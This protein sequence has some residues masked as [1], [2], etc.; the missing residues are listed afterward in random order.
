MTTVPTV[1]LPPDSHI[2][3][4]AV[5]AKALR[6]NMVNLDKY[7]LAQVKIDE[8]IPTSQDI[9]VRRHEHS[10]LCKVENKFVLIDTWDFSDPGYGWLQGVG[11]DIDIKCI[12]KIQCSRNSNYVKKRNVPI[13]PWTMFHM[14]QQEWL[15]NL[16]EFRSRYSSSD[17]RYDIGF[18]GRMWGWRSAWKTKLE[19]MS[20]AQFYGYPR[21]PPG[22]FTTYVYDRM[23]NWKIGLSIIGKRDRL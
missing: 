5:W 12:L 17:K 21:T 15:A 7:D 11:N 8:S 4:G 19:S 6:N 22:H 14:C 16:D 3:R 23:I 13:F 18:S 9:G 10:F 1:S 2:Y 20:N